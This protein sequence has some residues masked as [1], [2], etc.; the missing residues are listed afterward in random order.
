MQNVLIEIFSLLKD[1]S[2]GYLFADQYIDHDE[3]MAVQSLTFSNPKKYK[4]FSFLLRT[5]EITRPD[6]QKVW[7]SQRSFVKKLL[8]ARL[9]YLQIKSKEQLTA[10]DRYRFVGLQF[11]C[12]LTASFEERLQPVNLEFDADNCTNSWL[13]VFAGAIVAHYHEF[14]EVKQNAY[15]KEAIQGICEKVIDDNN[16]DLNQSF[17]N[18]YQEATNI[19]W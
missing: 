1:N 7:D 17:L 5:P 8:L 3:R 4:P 18:I 14:L 6:K 9:P 2:K 15:I 19:K 10:K 16:L 11:G 12:C 13:N